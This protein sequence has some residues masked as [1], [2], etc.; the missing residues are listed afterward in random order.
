MAPVGALEL[1]LAQ[2]EARLTEKLDNLIERF[3]KVSNGTGFPRCSDRAA[4]IATLEREMG[5]QKQQE[6]A[7]AKQSDLDKLEESYAWLRNVL[8]GS[9]ITSV[10][11]VITGIAIKGWG[12]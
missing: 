7:F 12:V 8:V 4:R 6:K 3:D 11:A 2:F 9:I 1:R 5:E 10:G